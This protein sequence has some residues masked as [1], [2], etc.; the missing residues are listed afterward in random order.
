MRSECEEST[1]SEVRP[2]LV[3]V[4]EE[5]VG[6]AVLLRPFRL[7]D[8]ESLYEAIDESREHLE[9]WM[10]WPAGY[11]T[12]DDARVNL[13]RAEARWILREDLMLGIFERETGRLLGGT[14]LH[15]LDWLIRSF[16]I[17]YWIRRDAEGRGYV[18]DAVRALTRAAFDQ[19]A[20]NRV[21]ITVDTRNQ[22]SQAV[23][24]RLG[25][26]HEGTFHNDQL[27]VDGTP[28]STHVY[29]LT[30]ESYDS[31]PWRTGSATVS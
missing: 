17:G 10:P 22:R 12:V 13:I 6:D 7:D 16:E 19:L 4:P 20:A 8:A 31:V 15:R 29:A 18:T 28:R 1:V 25:F 2:I 11:T 14:G 24:E 21:A 30:P 23:P 5:I 3:V 27:G 26:V 9:P